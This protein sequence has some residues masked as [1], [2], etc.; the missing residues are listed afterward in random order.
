VSDIG[1]VIAVILT[2]NRKEL[3]ANCLRASLDQTDPPDQI[4][5]LDNGSTDGTRDFL[6]ERGILD[7]SRIVYFGLK[8][9]IGPAPG[10]D[11]LTRLAY[12]AGCDWIWMMD[13][14]AIPSPNALRELKL[15]FIENFSSPEQIGFLTS[16][17][18]SRDGQPNNVPDIDLRAA[19]GQCAT[20]GELLS[21]GLVKVRWSTL[22]SALI[23]RATLIKVGSFSPQFYFSGEDIDF[24]LRVTDSLPGYLVGKSVVTHLRQLTGVFSILREPDPERIKMFFYYYRNNVFIRHKYYS[25]VR[26]LLYI[27]KAGWEIIQAL[28]RKKLSFRYLR[29]KVIARGIIMGLFFRPKYKSLSLT[30]EER[31]RYYQ[32][33]DT[34]STGPVKSRLEQAPTKIEVGG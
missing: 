17:I 31:S 33:R 32:T 12:D 13:D 21:R 16:S 27:G 1:K 7:D 2:Y 15:A 34:F 23:P 22:L 20:W 30:A 24:A 5:L 6:R 9:N 3:V 26:M 18:I 14:D 28:A 29:V 11:V 8:Q 25:D 10:F 19:D 4:F